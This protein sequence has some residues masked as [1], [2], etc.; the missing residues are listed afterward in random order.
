MGGRATNAGTDFQARVGAFFA[1][2]VLA[3][4]ELPPYGVRRGRLVRIWYEQPD[5]AGDDIRLEAANGLVYEIQA[6]HG[7]NADER[8]QEYFLE[9]TRIG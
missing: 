2:L 1:A 7:L 8:L 3:R 9:K 6:K 5:D 4:K